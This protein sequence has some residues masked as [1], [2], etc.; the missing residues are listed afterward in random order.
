MKATMKKRNGIVR[1]IKLIL[2]AVLLQCFVLGIAIVLRANNLYPSN[3]VDEASAAQK[4]TKVERVS[5]QNYETLTG[6][7]SDES[8]ID[9][10]GEEDER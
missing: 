7:T 3:M 5:D 2:L 9:T 1:G 8:S 4:K 10:T 6:N